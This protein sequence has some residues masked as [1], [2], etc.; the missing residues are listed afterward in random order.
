MRKEKQI[1]IPE[2]LFASIGSYFLLDQDNPELKEAIKKG[3]ADKLDRMAEH[4]YYSQYKNSNLSQEK[5]E[6]YRLKYCESKGIPTEF[7]W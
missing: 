7:R 5:R 2:S 3:I 6:E 4:E 1:A